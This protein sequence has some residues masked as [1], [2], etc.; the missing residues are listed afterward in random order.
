MLSGCRISYPLEREGGLCLCVYC[1]VHVCVLACVWV[2]VCVCVCMCAPMLDRQHW[3]QIQC[4]L[5]LHQPHLAL[6]VSM[7][8][9]LVRLIYKSY[10]L[11]TATQLSKCSLFGKHWYQWKEAG[12]PWSSF[13]FLWFN[14]EVVW[15][16]SCS[17]PLGFN[18]FSKVLNMNSS[19]QSHFKVVLE[20]F[21]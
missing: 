20:M 19:S 4:N 21:L 10:G 15:I 18:V 13:F 16:N 3:L 7:T 12:A 8:S 11:N 9:C 6:Q 1:H 5:V 2:C 17:D 14:V